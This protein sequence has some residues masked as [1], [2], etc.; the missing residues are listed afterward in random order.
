MRQQI[1]E[2]SG[3]ADVEALKAWS[4]D[5]EHHVA[6]LSVQI[7]CQLDSNSRAEL[8]SKIRG[9]V[10]SFGKLDSTIEFIEM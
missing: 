5:G 10:E 7:T 6:T 1:S 8:K 2:L 4:L 3:V 9:I